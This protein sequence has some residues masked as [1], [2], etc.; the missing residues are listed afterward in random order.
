MQASSQDPSWD[1]VRLFLA[2]F[3]DKTL[4]AAA[5]RLRL[6]TS[7]L[8]R[9]LSAFESDLGVRLFDRSREGLVATRAGQQLLPAA[10]AM[11]AAHARL[12]R[13]DDVWTITDLNATNGVIVIDAAGVETTLAPGASATVV[14]SFILGELELSIMFDAEGSAP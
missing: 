4:G 2:A 13:D 11:E 10:E 7:T 9:R 14:K 6:D 1:D 12:T 8:S 3:R 5:R